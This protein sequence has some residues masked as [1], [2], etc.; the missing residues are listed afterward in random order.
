MNYP[1]IAAAE[2]LDTHGD[3]L[4]R[5][6]WSML[7]SRE[8]AQIALRDTLLAAQAHIMRLT[9]PQ[10]PESFGPWLYSLARAECRQHVAVPAADAD[11]A[12]GPS[13]RNGADSRL[14]AW[15]AAMSLKAGEFE[16]LELA[17]RHDVDPG[18]VL[19]RPA[20]EVLA[21]LARA[22]KRLERALGV[23]I[24]LSR[25]PTCPDLAGVLA[26][27]LAGWAGPMTA[28]IR[29]RVLEHAALCQVC[30][31][32]RPRHVSA[33]RV[34]ALLPAPALSPLARAELLDSCA[35]PRQAAAPGQPPRRA[36]PAPVQVPSPAVQVPSPAGRRPR[37]AGLL[38]AGAGAIASAVVIASALALA[39]LAGKPGAAGESGPTTAL[40]APTGPARPASGL[41]AAGPVSPSGPSSV[42]AGHGSARSRLATPP[43]VGMAGG[44][45]Q[46]LIT[47]A[48]QPLPPGHAPAARNGTPAQPPGAGAGGAPASPGTLQLSTS[49]VGAGSAGQITLTAVGGV[50][51][52]PVSSSAPPDGSGR[53]RH[54]RHPPRPR[55]RPSPSAPAPSPSPSGTASPS[56]S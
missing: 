14:M 12:P 6:C 34:F 37:R 10:D 55:P 1:Q 46:G 4:F 28:R 23:E 13:G 35:G 17:S 38:I 32:K 31:D 5:Y 30:T 3:R 42:P 18:L 49:S 56:S 36:L 7:R 26:G 40:G 52:W 8:M 16:V 44:R 53:P 9:G 22:T 2:F 15:H 41:G 51:S 45:G 33:A 50:V 39:G 20:E 47:A 54:P 24:L 29:D 11:E 19:G 27:V 21:L 25:G 48:T 43:L